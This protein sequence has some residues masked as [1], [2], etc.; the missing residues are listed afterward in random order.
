MFALSPLGVLLR[1]SSSTS[2]LSK[3]NFHRAKR[4]STERSMSPEATKRLWLH[5]ISGLA[6]EKR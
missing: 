5:F 1:P 6:N 4:G 2:K 3:G